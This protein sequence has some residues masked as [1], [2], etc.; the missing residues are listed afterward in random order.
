MAIANA[1]LAYQRYQELFSGGAG[2]R[3]PSAGAQTQ[4][5]L[6][7][8]TGAKNPSY[9]DVVYVEEL[10]G[11]DTVNTMPPATLDAF[12]DHGRPRASLTEDV[13]AARDTMAA[14]AEVGISMKDVTDRLLA[15]GVRLFAD[16]FAKLLEAVEQAEQGSRRGKDQPPDLHAPRAAGRCGE[17][18]A[19][20]VARAGQGAAA[21]GARCLAVD[22]QGRG[23]VARLARHHERPAGPHPAVRPTS[24]RRPE[25]AG[26]SHVLLLRHGRIE[27]RA[28]R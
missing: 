22:R 14:L 18:F 6:W 28:R 16:A 7:A 12:R 26:F 11:P 10:I 21:L 8:S 2:R 25:R 19:G 23:A 17:R 13:D 24:P 20:G 5:L 1:K 27:P 4:R 3:W 9:R 15:E